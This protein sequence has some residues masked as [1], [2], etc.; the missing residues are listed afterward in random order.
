MSFTHSSAN[1]STLELIKG[2]LCSL[3]V[4]INLVEVLIVEGST[5]WFLVADNISLPPELFVTETRLQ[6][7]KLVSSNQ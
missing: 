2:G 1:S 7:S 3:A 6:R 5:E 4:L